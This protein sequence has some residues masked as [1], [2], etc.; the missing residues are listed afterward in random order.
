MRDA[1]GAQSSSSSPSSAASACS[2]AC[3]CAASNAASSSRDGSVASVIS[4]P[5][6]NSFSAGGGSGGLSRGVRIGRMGERAEEITNIERIANDHQLSDTRRLTHAPVRVAG[7][8]VAKADVDVVKLLADRKG[9]RAGP[10]VAS[11][12][13]AAIARHKA[14]AQLRRP[15]GLP[16]HLC[17]REV[18]TLHGEKENA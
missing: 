7:V 5:T 15:R 2:R 16:V 4:G 8:L 13:H 9:K 10:A 12:A 18:R 11:D 3:A 6:G 1:D 14:R 17:A